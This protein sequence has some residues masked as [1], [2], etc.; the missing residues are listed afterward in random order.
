[1]KF[2][3]YHVLAITGAIALLTTVSSVSV[4]RNQ[5]WLGVKFIA[6]ERG[7]LVQSV[8]DAGP[9]A[10]VLA[11]GDTIIR[12][13]GI[14]NYQLKPIARDIVEDPDEFPSF[15]EYNEFMARQGRLTHILHA[16]TVLFELN[17]GRQV[18]IP[19]AATRPLLSLPPSF[20][21]NQLFARITLLITAGIWCV[22][23]NFQATRLLL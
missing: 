9:S 23:R 18:R 6:A 11:P 1:M 16:P 4:V 3:L 13:S 7:L 10:R 2:T 15:S 19:P 8:A 14:Q 20:W 22:R 5:P 12:L 21:L 17:D